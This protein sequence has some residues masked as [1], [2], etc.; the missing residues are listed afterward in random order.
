MGWKK[1]RATWGPKV[2]KGN[3]MKWITRR[4]WKIMEDYGRLWKIMED[5]GRLFPDRI[6]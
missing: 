3:C 1:N 2:S 4:L 5:C 6:R